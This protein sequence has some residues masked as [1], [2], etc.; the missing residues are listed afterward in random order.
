MKADEVRRLAERYGWDARAMQAPAYRAFRNHA[1]GLESLETA[2]AK[3]IRYDLSL[4]KR[5]RTWFK[6][7]KSIHWYDTPV[8]WDVLVDEVTT[9][10]NT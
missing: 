4:A 1:E 10:L 5:Q 6:R 8:K 7:N 9:F 3:A 2:R